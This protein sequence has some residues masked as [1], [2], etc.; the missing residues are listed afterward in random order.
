M[1][2]NLST[3]FLKFQL[4]AAVFFACCAG[5]LESGLAD[6]QNIGFKPADTNQDGV[7][8]V[9]EFDSYLKKRLEDPQLPTKKIFDRLDQDKDKS[10]SEAEFGHRHDAIKH[11]MGDDYFNFLPDPDDPGQGYV[12]FRGVNE[13]IDDGAI[14]GALYHRYFEFVDDPSLK[15]PSPS[16]DKL[17]AS[18]ELPLASIERSPEKSSLED[19]IKS[20]AIIAGGNDDFFSGGA[21]VVSVDGLAVT[22]FHIAEM[23]KKSKLV[24]MTSD[25]KCHRVIEFLAGSKLRDIALIR[26]EGNDFTPAKIA[27]R[28]PAMGD[29]IVMIHHS[30]NRFYTYDRGYVMRH[31]RIGEDVWMEISA[32]YAP[33][34]SGCG[35]YNDRHELIGLVS[36]IQFGTGPDLAAGFSDLPPLSDSP[37][38]GDPA[39]S[40]SLDDPYSLDDAF[41]DTILLVK[42]A[43][44]LSAIRSVWKQE[45]PTK[46]KSE[47]ASKN[48]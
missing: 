36:T 3:R 13:P 38:E 15:W 26:L 32:D 11:F 17:P 28:H 44:P 39:S 21:V 18:C 46:Q 43:V 2:T 12:P 47:S 22:N 4:G 29:D 19:L 34:G 41:G 25:G 48:E 35:I 8:K 9:D 45:L 20:T 16:P 40:D 37:D 30:E 23:M 24:A 5:I 33:G 1:A 10:L 31:P 42:H 14:Y 7:V 6:D 27:S